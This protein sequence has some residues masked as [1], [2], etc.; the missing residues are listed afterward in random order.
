[1][2]KVESIIRYPIKS[3]KG[4]SLESSMVEERGLQHDR[5]WAVV[6]TKHKIMTGRNYVNLLSLRISPIEN[7]IEISNDENSI[8][9]TYKECSEKITNIDLWAKEQHTCRMAP[10]KINKW[11]SSHV[12]SECY[13]A[14]MSDDCY[15]EPRLGL[16]SGYK[17]RGRELVSYADDFPVLVVSE[18]SLTDLNNRLETPVTMDHFRPNIVVSGLGAYAEDNFKFISIGECVFE[19]AQ[20]CSRCVFTTIDPV[21]RQ[22]RTDQEPL[23]TLAKYRKV[24]DY[25][26]IFGVQMVPRKLGE[27]K[28]GDEV[29]CMDEME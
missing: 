11:L 2:A 24:K 12:G 17:A 13:L 22:K 20:H 9:V 1:M 15:R 23:R 27:I 28:V 16:A 6:D 26:V 3:S 29:V 7:G 4:M 19:F 21:T 10:E 5:R 8:E 14:Y 18:E 25:G